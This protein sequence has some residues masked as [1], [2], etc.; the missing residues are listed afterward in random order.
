GQG[1]SDLVELAIGLAVEL[2]QLGGVAPDAASARGQAFR[3]LRSGAAFEKL[4]E[5]VAAQGG[6]VG[7]VHDP[8]KLPSAPLVA[9][10]PS[11][12]AGYVGAIDAE[13]LAWT[14][15]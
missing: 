13:R 2:L 4:V 8:E 5:M 12:R 1:P 15:V 9:E 11:P 3:A 10:L 7:Q 14:T 6:D